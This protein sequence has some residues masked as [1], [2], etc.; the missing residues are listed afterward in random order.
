MVPARLAQCRPR[1]CSISFDTLFSASAHFLGL[2][3]SCPLVAPTGLRPLLNLPTLLSFLL[4]RSLL[5]GGSFSAPSILFVCSEI[6]L[7]DLWF[8]G[9]S[10][11]ASKIAVTLAFFPFSR[12]SPYYHFLTS[13]LS[14]SPSP[15]S[16]PY[17]HP[18][19][20]STL[21]SAMLFTT[22]LSTTLCICAAPGC[23]S[24]TPAW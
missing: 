7:T 22:I 2:E 6:R 14:P 17:T 21:T 9:F 12:T 5:P 24:C 19:R 10:F 8:P 20:L 3:L 18:S 16:Y 11:F 1:G 4:S 23:S 13:S 15:P